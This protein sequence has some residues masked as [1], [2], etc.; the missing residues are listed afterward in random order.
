L[1]PYEGRYRVAILLRFHEANPAA[2]NALLK[3]LEEP[4]PDAVLIL[5][6]D[7]ADH[8]LP[9]IVSRCQPLHLRPLPVETVREA[10][11]QHWDAPHDQAQTLA[12]LSGG[13][14]GWAIE[15]LENPEALETRGAA[16]DTLEAAL[17]GNRRERFALVEGLSADKQTLLPLLETWQGFWRDIL[18]IASG[19]RAPITN[20]DRAV[21]LND[22]AQWAGIDSAQQALQATRRTIDLLGKNVNTRLALEVLLLDYP[23]L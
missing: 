11:E 7:S 8:L 19:S 1:R 22:L 20:H 2:A 17:H 16:L 21:A 14:I 9:T 15:A 3:T 10:L 13:R 12:Q 4:S 18:L 23:G 5:T 6:A